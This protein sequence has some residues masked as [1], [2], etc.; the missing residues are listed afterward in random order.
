M[1]ISSYDYGHNIHVYS[2]SIIT[3]NWYLLLCFQENLHEDLS[4]SKSS[5]SLNK[6]SITNTYPA[7]SSLSTTN[8]SRNSLIKTGLD[9]TASDKPASSNLTGLKLDLTRES[10]SY[11]GLPGSLGLSGKPS[12]SG[13][14]IILFWKYLFKHLK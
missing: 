10:S 14:K 2:T 1:P 13:I 12:F 6:S 9:S 8:L 3:S 5:D 7:F 4:Q 11:F